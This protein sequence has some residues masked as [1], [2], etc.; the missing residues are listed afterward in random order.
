[1][2]F[3]TVGGNVLIHVSVPPS[4]HIREQA[5]NT[6]NIETFIELVFR[7]HHYHCPWGIRNINFGSWLC[8]WTFYHLDL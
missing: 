4:G 2:L 1:M 3:I 5:G 7:T 6:S 8:V